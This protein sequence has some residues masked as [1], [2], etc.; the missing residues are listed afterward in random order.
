ML[1]FWPELGPPGR[2]GVYLY[3][4]LSCT[5]LSYI[6]SYWATLHPPELLRHPNERRC[7]L[8]SYAAPYEAMLHSTE[9]CRTLYELRC[10]LRATVHP[11]S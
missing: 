3:T 4:G 9:L 2:M 7:T 11:L 8:L 5:L 10:I 6:A 1:P